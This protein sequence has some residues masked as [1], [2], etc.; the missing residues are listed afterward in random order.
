MFIHICP[1]YTGVWS[2]EKGLHH[3]DSAREHNLPETVLYAQVL[4]ERQEKTEA[5]PKRILLYR[6]QL[7][8]RTGEEPTMNEVTQNIKFAVHSFCNR[9]HMTRGHHEPNTS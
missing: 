7:R 2:W 3:K 6:H 9:V 4:K 1:K 5:N 8:C